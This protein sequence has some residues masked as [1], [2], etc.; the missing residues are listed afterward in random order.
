MATVRGEYIRL[1]NGPS[2]GGGG[3]PNMLEGR[4]CGTP[5]SLAVTGTATTVGAGPIVPT[6][7]LE[8]DGATSSRGHIRLISDADM[9]VE[10]FRADDADWLTGVAAPLHKNAYFIQSGVQEVIPVKSGDRLS[11][12]TGVL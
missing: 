1:G 11:F 10:V 4:G 7:D 2:Y 9:Y 12:I 5:F 8:G 3:W 6:F